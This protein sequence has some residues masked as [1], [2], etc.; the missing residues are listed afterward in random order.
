MRMRCVAPPTVEAVTLQQAKAWLRVD[1]DEENALISALI[2]AAVAH[3]DGWTGVLGR[4]LEEQTWER[5]LDGFPAGD[6]CLP[7][8]PVV[9]VASVAYVDGAGAAQ[10]MAAEGYTVTRHSTGA[11]VKPVDAWPE[12]R[13][14]I[15]TWVAGEGCP[16]TA[17]QAILMLVAHWWRN[18]EAAGAEATRE[19]PLGVAMLIHALR[20]EAF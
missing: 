10:V 3:L 19:T 16:E 12:G 5:Q 2:S 6:L 18:R 11:W 8:G 13:G 4:A 17:R 15:V 1:G 14:V 7:L 20:V 9:E